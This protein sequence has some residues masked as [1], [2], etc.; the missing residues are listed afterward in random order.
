M[1]RLRVPA[2]SVVVFVL[3]AAQKRPEGERSEGKEGFPGFRFRFFVVLLSVEGIVRKWSP[4]IW[5]SPGE[6]YFPSD[7]EDFLE[8]VSVTGKDGS[9]IS[10]SLHL[11]VTKRRDSKSHF[12]T[13]KLDL[14]E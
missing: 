1:V 10:N 8:N 13:T 6:V 12:L 3:V 7:V 14:S 5:L 4:L 11:E 2:I 9:L